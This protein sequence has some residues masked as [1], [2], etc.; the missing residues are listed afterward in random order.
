[1][2][3]IFLEQPLQNPPVSQSSPRARLTPHLASKTLQGSLSVR[4]C[5]CLSLCVRRHDTR[6]LSAACRLEFPGAE[7]LC[8]PQQIFPCVPGGRTVPGQAG[9]AFVRDEDALGNGRGC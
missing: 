9:Q 6:M 4:Q 2:I 1:M 3:I 5:V 8:G 7:T